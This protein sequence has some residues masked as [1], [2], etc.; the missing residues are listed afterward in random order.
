MITTPTPSGPPWGHS[1]HSPHS[2]MEPT[3]PPAAGPIPLY[4][5]RMPDQRLQDWQEAM[6]GMVASV[7]LALRPLALAAVRLRA[8]TLALAAASTEAPRG[9]TIGRKRRQGARQGGG[10]V[11]KNKKLDNRPL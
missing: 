11:T 10:A 6:V 1:S 9:P 3:P 2:T 5:R 4:Q 7:S 8:S